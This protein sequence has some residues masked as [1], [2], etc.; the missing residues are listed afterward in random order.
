M[1]QNE[2]LGQNGKTFF[3]DVVEIPIPREAL[4]A[5]RSAAAKRDVS[6]TALARRL[7]EVAASDDLVAAILDDD[8]DDRPC[9]KRF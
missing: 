8:S 5:L 1:A 4:R 6:T 9:S 3:A 7:V 2:V